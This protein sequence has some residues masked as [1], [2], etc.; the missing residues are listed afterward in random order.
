MTKCI[1]IGSAPFNNI[2]A[3][4]ELDWEHSYV[5]C[6]DGGVDTALKYKKSPDLIIGDFDSIRGKLPDAIETIKLDVE[7]DD[8]DMMAA[9]RI[10]LERG[11]TDF[12]LIGVLGGRF[13]HSIANLC[14][15]QYLASRSC[16]AVMIGQDCRVFLLN[17]GELELK[18]LKDNTVSVFPYGMKS[19]TVSYSG[20]Y[21]PLMQATLTSDN[22][23]GVSNKIIDDNAL[24]T[25][26]SGN[27]LIIIMT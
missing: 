1:L 22:P 17:G 8:T 11:F 10:A 4:N 20:L 26:H 14:V 7:K 21:Y 24:I 9:I 19:C 12:T 18:G 27:A 5:I 23:L 3:F 15:M 25:L 16:K 6:A 13:D 2:N